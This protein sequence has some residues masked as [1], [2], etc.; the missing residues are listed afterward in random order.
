MSTHPPIAIFDLD[1]TLAD[2]IHDLIATLNVVLASEGLPP[3]SIEARAGACRRRRQGADRAW[4]RRRS[5]GRSPRPG[6]T[7]CTRPSWSITAPISASTRGCSPVPSRRSIGSPRRAFGS[8]SAPTST[9]SFSIGLLEAL[10]VADRFAMICR[11]RQ[12]PLFQARSA[13]PHPYGRAGRRR[14]G[15]GR[16]GGRF[17]HRHRDRAGRR[18]SGRRRHLRLHRRSRRR[19]RP[20][21]GHRPFRWPFRRRALAPQ[22]RRL[23]PTTTPP[24]DQRRRGPPS[25]LS[26][27][28]SS[29]SA[30]R[31]SAG[32]G[33]G[34]MGRGGSARQMP[35]AATAA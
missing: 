33:S 35:S 15:A 9:S 4:A 2:T 18:N 12:L 5:D 24:P 10:G 7:S 34:R 14:P 31:R 16:H 17:P 25:Q 30:T 20:G 1:G 28:H 27:R 32:S 23:R 21:P 8:R 3:L 26:F 6:S 11:P 22:D 13:P 19:T 29:V